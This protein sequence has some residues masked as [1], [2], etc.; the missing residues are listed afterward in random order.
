MLRP[1][2]KYYFE[3]VTGRALRSLYPL[4]TEGFARMVAPAPGELLAALEQRGLEVGDRVVRP[5]LA[6]TVTSLVGDVIGV[7]LAGRL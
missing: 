4:A 6:A 2:G 5:R 3:W 7:G 1:G